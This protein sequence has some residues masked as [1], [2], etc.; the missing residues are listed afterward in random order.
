M[1]LRGA[2]SLLITTALTLIIFI[3]GQ[4]YLVPTVVLIALCVLYLW[5]SSRQSSEE[6]DLMGLARLIGAIPA[7][8][9]RSRGGL[10][11]LYPAAVILI[12]EEPFVDA[13]VDTGDEL[14]IDEFIL[15]QCIAPLASGSPEIIVAVLFSLRANAMSGIPTR[16]STEVNQL[17]LLIGSIASI[18][19]ISAG[20]S[21]GGQEL[22]NFPLYDHQS[23]E[24]LLTSAVSAFAIV[25]I[26]RRKIHWYAGVILLPL[27]VVHFPFTS[28]GGRIAVALI[29]AVLSVVVI[30]VYV[31]DYPRG[32]RNPGVTAGPDAE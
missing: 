32:R 20:N 2:L 10:L 18:F 7:W 14:G 27:F 9:R 15:I 24:F 23:E 17:P 3:T 1:D 26:W 8:Q 13:L 11:F 22:L 6:S 29:Y 28:S 16:P 12:A 30:G 19:S 25:L 5:A 31:R 4:L 21:Y